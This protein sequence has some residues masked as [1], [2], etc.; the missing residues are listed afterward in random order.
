MKYSAEYISYVEHGDSAI[1]FIT[2]DIVHSIDTSGKWIDVISAEG[3]QKIF[4]DKDNSKY[5]WDF[6]SFVIELFPRVTKPVY[7]KY[8]SLEDKKYITWVTANQDI[9]KWRQKGYKG[10]KYMICPKLVNRNQ[11]KISYEIKK[12]LW[13]K[14]LNIVV[15]ECLKTSQC[16]YREIKIPV[17][18]KPEWDYDIL[19][20]KKL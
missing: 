10:Q 14:R 3:G 5:R 19:S 9:D 6:K 16:E 4:T 18:A 13:N 15:P 7:P 12:E 8:T 1:V 2:R 20:V 11:G 17:P